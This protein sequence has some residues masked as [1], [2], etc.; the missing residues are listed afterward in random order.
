MTGRGML[1]RVL[2]EKS[3]EKARRIF[4]SRFKHWQKGI[5]TASAP[6]F[7]LEPKLNSC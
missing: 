2:I 1:R 7:Q 4:G 5:P 3:L 6:Q